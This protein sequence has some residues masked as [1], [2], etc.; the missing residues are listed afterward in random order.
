M[1]PLTQSATKRGRKATVRQLRIRFPGSRNSDITWAEIV[2][3][4][5]VNYP[6][7]LGQIALMALHRAGKNH[8][9]EWC[10][11]CQEEFQELKRAV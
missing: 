11:R 4:D 6:G 8:D 7:L 3:A 2:V 1:T 9:G 5:H 10:P